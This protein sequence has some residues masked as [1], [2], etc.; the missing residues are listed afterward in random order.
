MYK[1]MKNI[2][3]NL[4]SNTLL[5]HLDIIQFEQHT[6]LRASLKLIRSTIDQ[7]MQEGE[8]SLSLIKCREI[9]LELNE[10]IE[11]HFKEEENVLFPLIRKLESDDVITSDDSETLESMVQV[12]EY[13][14]NHTGDALHQLKEACHKYSFCPN[15]FKHY[16]ALMSRLQDFERDLKA[17]AINETQY[18]YPT[19]IR[20]ERILSFIPTSSY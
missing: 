19:A 5:D 7:A 9:F 15:S 8:P 17:H 2:Q 4:G 20:K 3:E 14:N 1:K 18:L 11:V 10:E 6:H 13:E 16:N 12:L